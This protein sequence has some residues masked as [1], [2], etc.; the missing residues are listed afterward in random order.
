MSYLPDY[1]YYQVWNHRT[2]ADAVARLS[3]A[4]NVFASD[5]QRKWF[6]AG[7]PGKMAADKATGGGKGGGTAAKKEST[8]PGFLGELS[9]SKR[10]RLF[11]TM[12]SLGETAD[13]ERQQ[14]KRLSPPQGTIGLGSADMDHTF[15][16]EALEG[17][18]RQ[19]RKGKTPAEA[20]TIVKEDL[21]RL[22]QSWNERGSKG[23]AT[24]SSGHELRRWENHGAGHVERA[25]QLL[26]Q[27]VK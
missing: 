3:L 6:F 1:Y 16:A 5:K 18:L 7:G 21:K 14:A 27:S 11:A 10:E 20:E 9:D 26:E 19:V 17:M 2:P 12:R 8:L 25:R 23:R 22:V 13:R 15:K 24:V 4:Q